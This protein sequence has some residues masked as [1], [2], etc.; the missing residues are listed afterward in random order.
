M[1]LW[2]KYGTCF[3]ISCVSIL[4]QKLAKSIC[5]FPSVNATL[6]GHENFSPLAIMKNTTAKQDS[7]YDC[8]IMTTSVSQMNSNLGNSVKKSRWTQVLDY[9]LNSLKTANGIAFQMGCRRVKWNCRSS[10]WICRI[11]KWKCLISRAQFDSKAG[12]RDQEA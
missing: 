3:A 8:P 10:S 12:T 7:E 2:K 6:Y 1:P 9:I 4:T 11:R 5:G